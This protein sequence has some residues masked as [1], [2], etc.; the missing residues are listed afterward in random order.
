M[1]VNVL[2]ERFLVILQPI[3]SVEAKGSVR[4]MRIALRSNRIKINKCTQL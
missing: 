4:T 1:P 2:I 3:N